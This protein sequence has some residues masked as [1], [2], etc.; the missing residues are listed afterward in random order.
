M[1]GPIVTY[2]SVLWGR[3][4][5]LRDDD[6]GMTTEAMIVTA[7]LAAGA[8]AAGGAIMNAVTNKGNDI[9]DDIQG[10]LAALS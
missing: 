1:L 2:M 4:Q 8:I 7:L 10:A 3:L 9:S 6:R 5:Q